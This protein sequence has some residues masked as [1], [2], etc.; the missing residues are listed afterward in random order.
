MRSVTT[1]IP[2]SSVVLATLKRDPP[3][4]AAAAR[5]ATRPASPTVTATGT[6]RFGRTQITELGPGLLLPGRFEGHL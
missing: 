4:A 6:G 2:Q 1:V 3:S 5:V